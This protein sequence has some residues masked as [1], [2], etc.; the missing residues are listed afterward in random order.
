MFRRT[1]DTPLRFMQDRDMIHT[2]SKR[3]S[4]SSVH[5][6]VER[7]REKNADGHTLMS[8][9]NS[10]ANVRCVVK[11]H[12]RQHVSMRARKLVINTDGTSRWSSSSWNVF[13]LERDS[14]LAQQI[15]IIVRCQKI[16][17]TGVAMAKSIALVFVSLAVFA[18]GDCVFSTLMLNYQRC[19]L[20][21]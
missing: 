1:G 12:T 21:H 2:A 8:T 3:L 20:T 4:I 13:G 9:N 10:Q 16:R 6:A 15:V 19:C 14:S 7:A 17:S 5:T 18:N 11:A